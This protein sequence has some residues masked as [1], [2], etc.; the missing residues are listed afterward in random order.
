MFGKI[1]HASLI[2]FSVF[3]SISF[4]GIV[5][6]QDISPAHE[7]EYMDAKAA[8]D[9]ARKV[10]AAKYEPDKLKDA[11][12][13]LNKADQA[14]IA[15]D[16]VQFS[17]ASHLARAFADSARAWTELKIEQEKLSATQTDLQKLKAE[18]KRSE[19]AK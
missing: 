10:N 6:A 8:I 3:I 15:K 12:D 7:Q 2:I 1:F 4:T 19:S 18:I 17:R 5:L 9:A 13:Y 14:R 11:A 16:D